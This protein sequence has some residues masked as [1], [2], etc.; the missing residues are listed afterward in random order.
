MVLYGGLV[1]CGTL[2]LSLSLCIDALIANGPHDHVLS[3][4]HDVSNRD[5]HDD[6]GRVGEEGLHCQKLAK[7]TVSLAPFCR[8]L[9]SAGC[10][11]PRTE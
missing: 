5:L 2:F 4:V 7:L 9:G 6:L 3:G 8:T 1:V 10:S 11:H